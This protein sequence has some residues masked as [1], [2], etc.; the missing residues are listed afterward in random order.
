MTPS[1]DDEIQQSLKGL[2]LT[3]TADDEQLQASTTLK[4]AAIS[5]NLLEL[6]HHLQSCSK[7]HAAKATHV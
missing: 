5:S 1:P 2:L 3:T 4:N 6:V 7:A